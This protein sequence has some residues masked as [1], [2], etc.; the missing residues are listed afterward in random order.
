MPVRFTLDLPSNDKVEAKRL[1]SIIRKVRC[2]VHGEVPARVRL[3]FPT[4]DRRSVVISGC[5]P[6]LYV[7]V[8]ERLADDRSDGGT[9][10]GAPPE[11]RRRPP[12]F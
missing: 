11:P 8:T 12:A 10:R 4:L 5:C 2:D 6:Q 7:V 1:A 3:T 9:Q